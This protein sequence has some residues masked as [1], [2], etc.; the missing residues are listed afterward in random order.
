MHIKFW[1]G[2]PKERHHLEDPE[3]DSYNTESKFVVAHAMW[4]YVGLEV[5][6]YSFLTSALDGCKWL[7]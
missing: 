7:P 6:I 4:S 1:V 3:I 2:I 5:Q